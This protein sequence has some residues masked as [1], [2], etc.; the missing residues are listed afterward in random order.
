MSTDAAAVAAGADQVHSSSAVMQMHGVDVEEVP[1][2]ASEGDDDDDDE[3]D[4][5]SER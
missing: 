5:Q 2:R 1:E 3:L 4:D